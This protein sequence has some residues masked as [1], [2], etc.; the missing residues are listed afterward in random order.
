MYVIYVCMY[1]RYV[2][3]LIHEF[4]CVS[5][6]KFKL[7]NFCCLALK[8]V[9]CHEATVSQIEY[10]VTSKL[11]VNNIYNYIWYIIVCIIVFISELLEGLQ[12]SHTLPPKY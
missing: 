3:I 12:N 8:S 1:K 4:G 10:V 7:F 2:R 6:C 5:G 9:D 11:M